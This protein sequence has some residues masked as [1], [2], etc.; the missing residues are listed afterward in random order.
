MR[1]RSVSALVGSVLVAVSLLVG[2]TV[3]GAAPVVTV[4]PSHALLNN[5]KVTVKGS[6]LPKTKTGSD[7]TW[8]V[9][10]CT[11]AAGK[12]HNLDPD[13]SPYCAETIVKPLRVTPGGTF[14]AS[15]RVTTGRVGRSGICGIPGRLTCLI[16]IGTAL[17]QHATTSISF[18]N[19]FPAPKKTTKKSTH[20]S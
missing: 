1:R 12:V 5:Q 19:L 7:I 10:E 3:A 18:K 4:S 6:G 14:T 8:F 17:G 16:G 2:A 20:K 15:F 11:P 9:T 13:Y